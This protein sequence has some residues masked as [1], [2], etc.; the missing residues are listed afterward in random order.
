MKLRTSALLLTLLLCLSVGAQYQMD[1]LTFPKVDNGEDVYINDAVTD[2]NGNVYVHT[3]RNKRNLING[4]SYD[5]RQSVVK[6]GATGTLDWEV[7]VSDIYLPQYNYYKLLELRNGAIYTLSYEHDS[8]KL[9]CISPSGNHIILYSD[10]IFGSIYQANYEATLFNAANGHLFLQVQ[11]HIP[12]DM[13]NRI[14]EFDTADA[15]VKAIRLPGILTWG[16][17]DFTGG[18]A[19]GNLIVAYL[20]QTGPGEFDRH[21]IKY[22]PDGTISWDTVIATDQGSWLALRVDSSG[23]FYV[24]DSVQ[25]LKFDKNKVLLWSFPLP[26]IYIPGSVFL[27]NGNTYLL[28]ADLLAS[29]FSFRA[30]CLLPDGTEKYNKSVPFSND[31]NSATFTVNKKGEVFFCSIYE[32]QQSIVGNNGY[33]LGAIATI[34][35]LDTLGNVLFT[36]QD[37]I[38]YP[39]RDMGVAHSKIAVDNN[40]NVYFNYRFRNPQAIP[41][42]M[43]DS[44]FLSIKDN[45]WFSAKYCKTCRH[46][47]VGEVKLDTLSNCLADSTEPALDKIL[48]RMNPNEKYAFSNNK[49]R[50]RFAE[51]DSGTHS[52]TMLP[53]AYLLTPCDTQKSFTLN[54]TIG[55]A[56]PDFVLQINPDCNGHITATATRARYGF[57]QQINLRYQNTGYPS[58]TG[59]VSLQFASGFN[60]LSANPPADSVSGNVY[61]WHFNSLP[62]LQ[63]FHINA[64]VQVNLFIG[65]T[66]AHKVYA[67]TGCA[68]GLAFVTDTLRDMVFG[69]YDPNDKNV[70]PLIVREHNEFISDTQTLTYQI[71]F[72]NT[73]N[74]TAFRVAIRDTLSQY[75]EVSTLQMIAASHP[76]EVQL[77]NNE[78]IEWVFNNI[79]LPDSHTNEPLSHGYARFSI[80]P[81]KG[82]PIH[83][84]VHNSAA[85]YFDYNEPIFTN[86]VSLEYVL[87]YSGINDIAADD[88]LLLYPNP[89]SD[90]LWLQA[91]TDADYE[92]TVLSIDGQQQLKQM[93]PLNAVSGYALHTHHLPAGMYLLTVRNTATQQVMHR[94]FCKQ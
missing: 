47:I 72:Q 23:N 46:N 65:N 2:N 13:P 19:Q 5:Y 78:T 31:V 45:L 39:V 85:I 50:Y 83:T 59:F 33:G 3:L 42:A 71:N 17:A 40:D 88:K 4:N 66:Y 80:K 84:L 7:I 93:T 67:S 27:N 56:S 57:T 52:I 75:V 53:P 51:S 70:W 15:F 18:D 68:Q 87:R 60:Y 82:I 21:V 79:L 9:H 94:K 37:T 64:S 30:I 77:L 34:H 26:D 14:L 24:K 44:V 76:Y 89:T 36:Y 25:L 29:P 55:S 48:L 8:I 91:A 16:A 73:G 81:K 41:Y 35:K 20:E 10:T 86:T 28:V 11:S 54:D 22:Q 63:S 32:S 43:F 90:M 1:W 38:L 6:I 74:D 69:S 62:L 49:G 58:Q 61:F 92:I 12:Q